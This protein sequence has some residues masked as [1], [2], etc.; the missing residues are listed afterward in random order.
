MNNII[1]KSVVILFLVLSNASAE[2]LKKFEISGNKR[3]SNETIIIFSEIKINE[4]I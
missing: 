3:I 2:V 1:L 4:E